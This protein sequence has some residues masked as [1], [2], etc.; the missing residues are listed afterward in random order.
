MR[1]VI[2]TAIT[3]HLFIVLFR[4]GITSANILT[5]IPKNNP[6]NIDWDPA[7][8][9]ENGPPLSAGASRDPSLL[10]AQISGIVGAYLF[11]VC[12]IVV[13]I[14]VVGR[15]VRR[16]IAKYR[17]IEMLENRI[18]GPAAIETNGLYSPYPRTVSPSPL[19]TAP[20]NFSWKGT[21]PTPYVFPGRTTSPRS[22]SSPYSPQTPASQT[23]P[24]VDTRVVER[25]QQNLQRDLEDIYA[26]VMEQ[27][28]AKA[29][30]ISVAE[31]PLPSK[32]QSAGPVPQSAPQRMNSPPSPPKKTERRRPSN[33]ETTE[34]S[35][36]PTKSSSRSS[37]IISSI[38]S[39]RKSSSALKKLQISS[40]VASPRWSDGPSAE[41]ENEPLTPRYYAPPPPPPVPKD[42]L[43]YHHRKQSQEPLS[44]TKSIAEQLEPYGPGSSSAFHKQ[45]ASQ[46]SIPTSMHSISEQQ[47]PYTSYESSS[48]AHLS[49]R[50]APRGPTP[51]LGLPTLKTGTP[52]P[53]PSQ[54][55][56]NKSAPAN[57]QNG[58][59][60][61]FRQ[62]EPSITSPSYTSFAQA[63]STKTTVLERK[64]LRDRG[65]TTGGVP[66]SAGAT[67]YSP[68][69]PFTPMIPITPRLVTREE[70]KMRERLERKRGLGTPRV[71]AELVKSEDDLWDSGY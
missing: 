61:P 40:P 32:L 3:A 22:P 70:R 20:R 48:D 7:P 52:V 36:N 10:P 45:N 24:N 8:A 9:P 26:H 11:T 37:S 42:Q 15:N 34:D 67:P 59:A 60:L 51:R 4:A 13:A 30:G 29:A 5:H 54:Q 68:Y 55:P 62:F 43:P 16:R 57:L 65:M 35:R 44:P 46:A 27:E 66:W 58:R 25:D 6:L 17:D 69:Q 12:I 63:N 28:A 49:P 56:P 64:D 38:M 41:E 31:L 71:Q 21:G 1:A 39:P 47:T 53:T 23:N 19:S 14:Y 33:I 50:V 18:Y 2:E